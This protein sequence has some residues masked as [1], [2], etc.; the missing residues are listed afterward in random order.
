MSLY[1]SYSYHSSMVVLMAVSTSYVKEAVNPQEQSL[2]K[3]TVTERRT[4]IHGYI[5]TLIVL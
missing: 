4:V 5:A 2:C 3:P 1:N